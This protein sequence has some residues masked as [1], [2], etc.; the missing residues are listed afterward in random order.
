MLFCRGVVKV[1][2]STETFAMGVNAPA[3][4][5]VF[6]S[7][8]WEGAG[9]MQGRAGSAVLRARR[10]SPAS[11]ATGHCCLP[12]ASRRTH[13]SSVAAPGGLQGAARGWG[14]GRRR[15]R[16][17]AAGAWRQQRQGAEGGG[18]MTRARP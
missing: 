13:H 18:G 15:P 7:L 5:V 11:G 10:R 14:E 6:Q 16:R 17:P 2:L 12:A 4:T 3:R 9:R 1:L 8:R